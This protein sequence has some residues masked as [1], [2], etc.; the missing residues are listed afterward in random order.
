[1]NLKVASERR[2]RY[3]LLSRGGYIIN[4]SKSASW[5]SCIYLASETTKFCRH[6]SM[7]A[8]PYRC[9]FKSRATVL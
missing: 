4:R 8:L 3:L 6:H 1:M 7:C 9:M 2:Y 5:I